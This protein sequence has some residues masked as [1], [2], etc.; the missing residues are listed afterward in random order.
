[1]TRQNHRKRAKRM[2]ISNMP[3]KVFKVMVIKIVTRFEKR[4][5]S[6]RTSTR[7]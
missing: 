4:V 7:R 6:V 2:E 1:M 5:N 3:N